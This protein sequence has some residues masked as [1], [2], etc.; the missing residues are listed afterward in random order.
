MTGRRD[1]AH[2]R[3]EPALRVALSDPDTDQTENAAY[4]ITPAISLYF[5]NT[6][7]LRA[8]F[9]YYSY[10]LGTERF[11]AQQFIMSWQANF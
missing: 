4:L 1:A 6:V 3:V 2:K 9:D 10:V 7:I 8:G 11:S 5:A